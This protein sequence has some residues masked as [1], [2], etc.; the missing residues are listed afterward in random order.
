MLLISGISHIVFCYFGWLLVDRLKY[1]MNSS[2]MNGISITLGDN[3]YIPPG[4]ISVGLR[5][6]PVSLSAKHS[7]QIHFAK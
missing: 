6:S 3:T 5:L 7:H 2:Y 1:S 4:G